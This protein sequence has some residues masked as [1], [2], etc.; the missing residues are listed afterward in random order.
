VGDDKRPLQRLVLETLPFNK[1]SELRHKSLEELFQFSSDS[2]ASPQANAEVNSSFNQ[3]YVN[4]QLPQDCMESAQGADY[5]AGSPPWR[6]DVQSSDNLPI[7]RVRS[8]SSSARQGTFPY[9]PYIDQ[10]FN[11]GKD[12]VHFE[13]FYCSGQ[14]LPP[15]EGFPNPHA[16][17]LAQEQSGDGALVDRQDS[18][19][20]AQ[21]Q[22][23]HR[24]VQSP[25]WDEFLNYAPGD[26]SSNTSLSPSQPPSGNLSVH[27]SDMIA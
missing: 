13:H 21:G 24:E 20:L 14:Q 16:D 6:T 1:L 18:N 7:D 19:L 5:T 8:N 27:C 4:E 17:Q 23:S 26:S 22:S 10:R 25:F 12:A 9:P 2:T 15:C 3:T 11:I